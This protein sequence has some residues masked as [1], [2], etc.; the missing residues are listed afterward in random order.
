MPESASIILA[1]LNASYSH[2]AFGLRYL[3]A[4]LGPLAKQSRIIEFTIKQRPLD[5]VETILAQHPRIVGL[6]IY[7]WNVRES[8][9]I[10]GMIK[11]LAPE[12]IIVLG[13][14]EVSHETEGQEIVALADYTITGEADLAFTQLCTQ[15]LAG[16]RP[17]TK[18]IP[19]ALPHFGQLQLPYDLYSDEDL[20]QRVVYVEASR[21]C[22]FTCEFCLSSLD[23][24]VRTVPLERLLPELERLISRGLRQF[25]FVD[26]TF[27]LHLPTS[28]RLLQFF[29]DHW[30][31]GMFLHFE[32]IPDRLPDG[33]RAL[34]TQFPAG[35]LQFEVGI[36]T[37]QE[38]ASRNISRRNNHEKTADNFA[39]LR[40]ETGVHIHAD[41]IVGLPGENLASFGA[42]FD[43]LFAM[44]PQEIQVGI[45]KRLRGT[46]IIRHD[47]AY[48]MVYAPQPPYEI[49]Q[50]NHISFTEMQRLRRFAKYWDLIGNSG[51]FLT[52]L[53]LLFKEAPSPFARFLALSD[54]LYAQ[55][56]TSD[57]VALM[58]LSQ[59]I[60]NYLTEQLACAPATAAYQLWHDYTKGRIADQAPAWLAQHLPA[61]AKSA[62]AKPA[63]KSGP[64][65]QQRH[66]HS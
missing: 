52:T 57:S 45:L 26:R 62:P 21:G 5:I 7:I 48:G 40:Q 11:R 27:N 4:N 29:L 66:S 38:E 16:E 8:L 47:A 24:P 28:Q 54:W 10:V 20:T 39:F 19:A 30:Q 46:P 51:N 32:M 15:L 14:P 2:A 65:R 64:S 18:I 59:L 53:P 43:R 37:F 23:I 49:L 33:L 17:D 58:R 31:D 1:T 55:L 60:F 35:A 36:Q 41:L 3:Q 34:I 42:G 63:A 22:P 12:I 13:G 50:N 6:G 61:E 56:G 9:V 25:K 44:G